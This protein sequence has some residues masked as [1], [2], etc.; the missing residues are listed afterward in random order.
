MKAQRNKH[1][2]LPL[3]LTAVMACVVAPAGAAKADT[4]AVVFFDNVRVFDGKQV[5]PKADVLVRNGL[6]KK[7]DPT[8]ATTP[9]TGATVVGGT[10]K[11]LM[12]GLIDGHTHMLTVRDM[13]DA[14]LYGVTTVV[15][16]GENPGVR[17]YTQCTG[18]Q[19]NR[20]DLIPSSYFATTT[21]S[22]GTELP[23]EF[24]GEI[25]LLTHVSQVPGWVDDRIAEG[26]HHIKVIY[27]DHSKFQETPA[28]KLPIEIVEAL[29]DD[30]HAKGLDVIGHATTT[31][32]A[33][34]L[35]KA[36]VDGLTH[37]P[38]DPID[39]EFLD[40]MVDT[41]AHMTP[42]LD[43]ER[44]GDGVTLGVGELTDPDLSPWLSPT[45]L[46]FLG[47]T[48]PP[49]FGDRWSYTDS[50]NNLAQIKAAG[51][52][53]LAGTDNANPGVT[54]GAGMHRELELL[55]DAGLTPK[56]A[57]RSATNKVAKAYGLSD[58]GMVKE[59]KLA[60]LLLVNGN[61]T[62]DVLD[63]RKIAGIWRIG[64]PVD[65]TA[66][67]SEASAPTDPTCTP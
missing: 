58:R 61:P 2:G 15:S 39:Q 65:R 57:L 35:L 32:D 43:V 38:V 47:L 5:I 60:D 45:N 10:G 28:P 42:T 7:V 3:L 46:F 33:K 13:K 66:L 14:L 34:E 27:E 29:V 26:A 30:A 16:A 37:V 8:H 41:G 18:P 63:S 56:Q 4:G 59:G 24:F 49:G 21:G 53:V 20:A 55:V 64:T 36:G 50:R 48:P 19:T 51:I 67:L 25:P 22:H 23:P 1:L 9:P 40:L 11:T 44:A 62:D 52:T 31:A 54:T 12:P 17:E 6:I